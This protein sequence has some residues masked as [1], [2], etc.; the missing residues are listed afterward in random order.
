MTEAKSFPTPESKVLDVRILYGCITEQ[1]KYH[2]NSK[3]I[4]T[5]MGPYCS[6]TT[7]LKGKQYWDYIGKKDS[8]RFI[9][10]LAWL[11]ENPLLPHSNNP[12]TGEELYRI[13][14]NRVGKKGG[15]SLV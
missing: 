7:K 14:K 5:K 12:I 4:L 1:F 9:K 8:K 10:A 11:K 3:G 6:H 13:L 2:R 15:V